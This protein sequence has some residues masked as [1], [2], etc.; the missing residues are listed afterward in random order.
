MPKP[1]YEPYFPAPERAVLTLLHAAVSV[2][3]YSLRDA[4]P[5]VDSCSVELD[6]HGPVD[7]PAA[8]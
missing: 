7:A 2:T 1:F 3:E 4:H 8:R 6:N 5:R